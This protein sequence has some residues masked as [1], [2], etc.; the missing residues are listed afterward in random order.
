MYCF[1]WNTTCSSV[2][3]DNR[4]GYNEIPIYHHRCGFGKID[5]MIVFRNAGR[6]AKYLCLGLT[7]QKSWLRIGW[8]GGIEQ[9]CTV[10]NDEWL[11]YYRTAGASWAPFSW[12]SFASP[13][14]RNPVMVDVCDWFPK[15]DFCRTSEGNSIVV[16]AW[17]RVVVISG[18]ISIFT[19]LTH[20]VLGR[21]FISILLIICCFY[22]ASETHVVMKTAQT[23]ATNL[24]FSI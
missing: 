20:S 2:C 12:S 22:T 9:Q 5:P 6:S 3:T 17:Q 16:V 24:L 14:G 10:S 11:K 8:L 4:K 1:W 7:W 21:V 13:D 19:V 18:S 15:R 23:M